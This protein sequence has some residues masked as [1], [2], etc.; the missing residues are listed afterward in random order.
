MQNI[1]RQGRRKKINTTEL[2]SFAEEKG[3]CVYCAD[4][5]KTK[6]VSLLSSSGN[7]YIGIDPFEIETEAEERVHLAHEIGHC[8]KGAFY[9]IYSELDVRA[10]HELRADRWA[11]K[12]LI[13]FD[14]FMTAL[15]SGTTEVWELADYFNVTEDFILKAVE[16][17]GVKSQFLNV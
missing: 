11:I 9:N 4:L 12:K 2:Y 3:I 6:S 8:E 17:Y 7:C 15:K 1:S 16:Y 5:P 14:E 10:R 13:P